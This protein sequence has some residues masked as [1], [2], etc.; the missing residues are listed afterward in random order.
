MAVTNCNIDMEALITDQ[1]R[2]IATLAITTLLKTGGDRLP[3]LGRGSLI[4]SACLRFLQW[5]CVVERSALRLRKQLSA[6]GS[7]SF[8]SPYCSASFAIEL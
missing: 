1:N 7:T 5:G 2:S 8:L 6:P 3:L 4:T